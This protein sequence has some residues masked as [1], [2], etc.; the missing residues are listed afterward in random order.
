MPEAR[1]R[2]AEPLCEN[3]RLALVRDPIH[4][5]AWFFLIQASRGLRDQG[6]LAEAREAIVAGRFEAATRAR[7]LA[8]IDAP[9]E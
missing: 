2:P 9:L 1:A 3:R 5:D 4:P 7:L 8:T 6:A